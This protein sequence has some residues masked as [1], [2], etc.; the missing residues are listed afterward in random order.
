MAEIRQRALTYAEEKKTELEIEADLAHIKDAF[1]RLRDEA[2]GDQVCC[3]R[4]LSILL[5][6]IFLLLSL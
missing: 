4:L 3:T 5:R 6:C 1:A 2:I